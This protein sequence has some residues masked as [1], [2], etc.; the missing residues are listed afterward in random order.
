M[1]DT[2]AR[3]DQRIAQVEKKAQQ[4]QAAVAAEPDGQ[5]QQRLYRAGV[6]ELR[7]LLH[8]IG[9]EFGLP[10]FTWVSPVHKFTPI[11]M[12]LY[13]RAEAVEAQLCMDSWRHGTPVSVDQKDL[14]GRLLRPKYES[15][16]LVAK[17]LGGPGDTTAN[18]APISKA[19][20]TEMRVYAEKMAHEN[21]DGRPPT[22]PTFD[23]TNVLNYSVVCEYPDPAAFDAWLT[24]RFSVSPGMWRDLFRLAQA[25]TL[26]RQD[27][28]QALGITLSQDDYTATRER[29]ADAFLAS[30]LV[31][32]VSVEQGKAKVGPFYRVSNHR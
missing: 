12:R 21:L 10:G 20:N 11:S 7:Q 31:I 32:R 9:E 15:G 22:L 27:F 17:V 13:G 23:P 16:H 29:L 2:A 30:H 8:Q 19:T 4:V 1:A 26:E 14:P 5:R 6:A 24:S 18:L 3:L 25:N 28:N